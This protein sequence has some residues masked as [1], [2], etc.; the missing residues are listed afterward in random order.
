MTEALFSPFVTACFAETGMKIGIV[1]G[2]LVLCALIIL[3]LWCAWRVRRKEEREL[4]E[5]QRELTPTSSKAKRTQ[6]ERFA[7]P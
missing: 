6:S 4:K 7:K 2:C 5:R 1:V 3:V